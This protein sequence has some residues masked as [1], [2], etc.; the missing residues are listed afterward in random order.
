M[1][2]A[3]GL[4]TGAFKHPVTFS[5]SPVNAI[6]YQKGT[7]SIVGN[8]TSQPKTGANEGGSVELAGP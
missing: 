2:K 8:F 5:S 7:P 3:T 4:V 1:S 6:I